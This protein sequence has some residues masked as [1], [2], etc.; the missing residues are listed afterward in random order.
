MSPQKIKE[1]LANT[2]PCI[3][4]VEGCG[5]FHY[6]ARVAQSFGH[7]VRGMAPKKVKPYVSQQKTDANDAVGIAVASTQ[8]GMT[9]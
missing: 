5:S 4:S 8:L 9:F 7:E 1:L 6:W 3:V 2:A